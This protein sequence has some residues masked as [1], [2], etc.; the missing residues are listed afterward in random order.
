MTTGKTI[1]LTRW[2]FV[3]KVTSQDCFPL[4]TLSRNFPS[5]PVVKNLPADAR[6]TGLM[7]GPGTKIPDV[8][9]QLSKTCVP[10]ACAPPQ[11]K[12]PQPAARAAQ[13]E[14]SSLLTAAREGPQA[15]MKTQQSQTHPA[16][17][18]ILSPNTVY[19]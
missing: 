5:G 17:T 8:R 13:L 3:G 4:N 7:P 10:R 6:D 1:A 2:T 15:A 16:Q 12:P 11:Q 19:F 14:I 18:S 9:G